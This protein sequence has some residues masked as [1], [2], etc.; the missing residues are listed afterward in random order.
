M[1]LRGVAERTKD[2]AEK[3]AS[4]KADALT[5][6]EVL[7][8]VLRRLDLQPESMGDTPHESEVYDV[9]SFTRDDLEYHVTFQSPHRRQAKCICP[10]WVNGK[11]WYK[12]IFAA[13]GNVFSSNEAVWRSPKQKARGTR[14]FVTENPHTRQPT[15][16]PCNEVRT[17]N[18][19]VTYDLP[20]IP[21]D[22]V[23]IQNDVLPYEYPVYA[24]VIKRNGTVTY[25]LPVI[26]HNLAVAQDNFALYQLRVYSRLPASVPNHFAL[27]SCPI[28]PR[29]PAAVF[30][31]V[32]AHQHSASTQ[33]GLVA[34]YGVMEDTVQLTLTRQQGHPNSFGSFELSSFLTLPMFRVP[35]I[36]ED[37]CNRSPPTNF[38]D[39]S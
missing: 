14:N 13:L 6:K 23:A 3:K 11:S 7:E 18:A 30:Y 32:P 25:E 12:Y 29:F 10:F 24:D 36:N 5:K 34:S 20:A 28:L 27:Y 1:V 8:M 15:T 37:V 9:R 33:Y 26:R 17:N 38:I 2:K 39:S 22:P 19:T 35:L 21:Q 31:G 4:T 16:H